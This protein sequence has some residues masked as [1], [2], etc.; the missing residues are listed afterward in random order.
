VISR[1]R[2][3]LGPGAAWAAA[4]CGYAS[5]AFADV[6][7]FSLTV[8]AK[9]WINDWTSWRVDNVFANTGPV[10][11]SEPLHSQTR[12]TVTP[13]VSLRYRNLLLSSSYLA[14]ADYSLKGSLATVAASR[15]EFDANAG[16][17]LLPGLTVV[18]GYKEVR[19]DYGTGTFKWNGPTAGI[20][21][22]VPIG[23]THWSLYALYGYGLLK[24]K[25]PEGEADINGR[26]SFDSNYSVLEGGAAY[27]FG[28]DSFVKNLRLT[29]GYRAQVLTTRG[30][31]LLNGGSPDEQDFTQGVTVGI[32]TSF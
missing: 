12:F 5:V 18:L 8:G 6:H 32:S 2:K 23:A 7:D 22:S 21:G 11:I 27:D 3:L 1:A 30:Y 24:L 25:V 20:A 17:Y 29:I 13:Q 4:L 15:S 16:Y 28:F 31:Q 9:G 19:Q 26:T 10:Q 14:A